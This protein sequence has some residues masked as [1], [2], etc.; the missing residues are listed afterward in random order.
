MATEIIVGEIGETH[1]G[2]AIAEDI[3]DVFLSHR[4]ELRWIAEFL[5]GSA[6]VADACVMDAFVIS[7]AQ[8]EANEEQLSQCIRL[9]TISSAFEIQQSRIAQLAPF[10]EGRP[11]LHRRHP[12]LPL[13]SIEFLIEESD[14]VESR[15]D[16][17]C[18]F[19]LI[20]CGV[21]QCSPCEAA[22]LL[23]TSRLAV[24]AAYCA[25]VE[26]LDTIHCQVLLE[27]CGG[28]LSN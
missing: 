12:Q 1:S 3:L 6:E 8:S 20:L 5:T 9:A 27:S 15:L 7:A 2:C 28:G 18:R 4:E 13:H 11:C 10:Y 16:A 21:E 17:L 14:L 24:E 19:V 26:S 22:R 25:A 23:R